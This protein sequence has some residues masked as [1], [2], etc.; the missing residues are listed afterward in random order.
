M[1]LADLDKVRLLGQRR[2]RLLDDLEAVKA[3]ELLMIEVTP[4]SRD[5]IQPF[6]T[7]AMQ[8]AGKRAPESDDEVLFDAIIQVLDLS[9]AKRVAEIE[10]ELV[11]LG[12]VLT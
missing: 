11:Q 4:G 8:P 9:L 1:R 7:T 5:A 6:K 10:R 12:V 3:G 2:Q